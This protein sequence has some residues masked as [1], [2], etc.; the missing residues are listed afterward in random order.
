LDSKEE[1]E[2]Q[3]QTCAIC[4]RPIKANMVKQKVGEAYFVI[5][6]SGCARILKKLYS[7]YGNDFC[8]MLKGEQ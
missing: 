1:E 3:Q 7:V 4:G 6:K 8:L 2:E 5:D